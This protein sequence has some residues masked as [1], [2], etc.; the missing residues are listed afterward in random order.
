MRKLKRSYLSVTRVVLCACMLSACTGQPEAIL[1]GGD[2]TSAQIKK[3][4]QKV[5]LGQVLFFDN[6]LSKNRTQSCA[7]C[8][9]PEVAFT[10]PRGQGV[11]RAASLGDNATSL[12]DRNAPSVAYA[13]LSPPFYAK[14]D[15]SG[16]TVYVG[17]QF[18]D[19]RA[20]TL[21][22]Q[23]KAP[24]LNPD[25]MGMPNIEAVVERLKENPYYQSAFAEQYGKGI[26]DNPTLAFDA[27]ADAIAAF[28]SSDEIMPFDS[29]YDRYLQGKATFTPQEELGRILF[30]S[31]QFTNCN[32]CHQLHTT[33]RAREPFSNFEYHNIGVPKH[34]A[35]RHL[36]GID[37]TK[38]EHYVD[39]GLLN[40]SSVSEKRARGKFKTPTLRNVAITAP[41]MHNGV[42]KSLRTVVLFYNHF[43]SKAASKQINPETGKL[44]RPAE[45]PETVAHD[46]LTDAPAMNDKRIDAL[47]AFMKT[48]TDKRYEHL[49]EPELKTAKNDVNHREGAH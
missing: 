46:L 43:N 14:S 4:E 18:L 8:H 27:M 22:D 49:L 36:N 37:R 3:H 1:S 25:E 45:I 2:D 7:T 35:L 21:S 44:W 34:V 47:V 39:E 5:Q 12:G 11:S 28:E 17:G 16:Q 9:S 20:R 29:K 38:G 19:G 31:Q 6:N 30:F 26:L 33:P 10:D 15:K 40:N 48:L 32:Q 13:A 41:Y 24:P 42:F 23:A